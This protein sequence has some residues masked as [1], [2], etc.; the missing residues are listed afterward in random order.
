M[1]LIRWV[2]DQGI[3]GLLIEHN[4][5]VVMKVCNRIVV[6]DHRSRITEGALGEIRSNPLVIQAYLGKEV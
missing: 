4:I 5:Q 1:R 6:I 2:R 3:G